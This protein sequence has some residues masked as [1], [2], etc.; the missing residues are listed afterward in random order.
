MSHLSYLF[1]QSR[2]AIGI[3]LGDLARACGYANVSRGANRIQTFER[4]GEIDPVL[5]GKLAAVLG[6]P[7]AEI[8]RAR[9]EDRA[10]WEAGVSE[11]IE[12]HLIVRLVAAFYTRTSIP[13]EV[14]GDRGAMEEFAADYA[15]TNR[16]RVCLVLSRKLRVW[17]ERDGRCSAV[18]EDTFTA[19]YTTNSNH[20]CSIDGLQL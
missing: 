17:F 19:N 9:A 15:A 1:L 16:V 8:N 5:F 4:T 3:S 14:N 6:I 7:S 12:P 20:N 18:T 10:E 13:L 11:P 2:Q